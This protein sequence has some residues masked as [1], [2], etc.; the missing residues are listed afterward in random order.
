[1]TSEKLPT[2][3]SRL[4][5]LLTSAMVTAETFEMKYDNGDATNVPLPLPR[6]TWI[7]PVLD[8]AVARSSLPSR[9]TSP[10]GMK[11][12]GAAA[13]EEQ[14][15]GGSRIRRDSGEPAGAVTENDLQHIVG[16]AGDGHIGPSVAV[17]ITLSDRLRALAGDERPRGRE[18][19]TRCECLPRGNR[20]EEK[21]CKESP[22]HALSR[23]WRKDIRATR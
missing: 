15:E 13:N 14:I 17:E 22:R 21:K 12:T 16:E 2:T 4:P 23:G 19:G 8:D 3:R 20:H 7:W 10:P 1:M 9:F 11:S 6:K 5:S 18:L